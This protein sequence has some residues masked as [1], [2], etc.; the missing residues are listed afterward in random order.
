MNRQCS[1][2]G[3]AE[4]AAATLTYVYGR[5]QV[6]IDRLTLDRDPHGYDL[7]IRHTDR[8]SVPQGWHL[9]DRRVTVAVY[10]TMRRLA[11]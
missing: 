7:C 5:A 9:H 1:R 11:G 6:W 10:T 3:C 4:P 8:V 2:S